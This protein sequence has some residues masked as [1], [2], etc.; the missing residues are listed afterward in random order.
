MATADKGPYYTDAQ[1]NLHVWTGTGYEVIPRFAVSDVNLY[2]ARNGSYD[3]GDRGMEAW[4]VPAGA[5]IKED[6][7][8]KYANAERY[9]PLD[10]N[11]STS[12]D[13]GDT[14]NL[15]LKSADKAGTNVQF[16]RQGEYWVP[17]F[18][19]T[20]YWDTN[21]SEDNI[22]LLRVALGVAGGVFGPDISAAL[23][24]LSGATTAADAFTLSDAVYGASQFPYG[25]VAA[26]GSLGGAAG[27]LSAAE[28]AAFDAA[29][30]AGQGLSAAQIEATLAATGIDS[31]VAADLAQLA[32]QGLSPA[33]I[34]Q[35]VTAAYGAN[36]GALPAAAAPSLGNW[37]PG[38][39][40]EPYTNGPEAPP[41]GPPPFEE[42]F[43]TGGPDL[44]NTPPLNLGPTIPE[45]LKNPAIQK[46]LGGAAGSLLGKLTGSDSGGSGSGAG[47]TG[48]PV[49]VPTMYGGT[50]GNGGTGGMPT[51]QTYGNTETE[52]RMTQQYLPSLFQQG[53]QQ[54][55]TGFG[56]MQ[57]AAGF[58]G[59]GLIGSG[60]GGQGTM[61]PK[62]A[63]LPGLIGLPP[64]EITQTQNG[65]YI[66]APTRSI[67]GVEG[68]SPGTNAENGGGIPD[69][70]PP[71]IRRMLEQQMGV[72]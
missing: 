54:N 18:A 16:A 53:G 20:E 23:D 28:F 33:A 64:G 52:R 21:T 5:S 30:L 66:P 44:T 41:S 15:K 11:F 1:G 45:W 47:P 63:S 17:K 57:S 37:G 6:A 26:A 68:L 10:D 67:P 19:G 59:N 65:G 40:P 24:S 22:G 32:A 50:G 58:G 27:T 49:Q 70:I 13:G 7:Y 61:T 14:W 46:L 8:S 56:P 48:G 43:P 35:N 25:E 72:Y 42:N 12:W 71:H 4:A 55:R 36:F 60:I 3:A 69:S 39:N 62:V 51:F 38:E 34:S 9:Q 2:E 31:F 29:Q